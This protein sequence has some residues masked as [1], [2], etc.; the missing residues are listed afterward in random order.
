M[1]MAKTIAE[2]LMSLLRAAAFGLR[3]LV[4]GPQPRARKVL[5]LP[6]RVVVKAAKHPAVHGRRAVAVPARSTRR[7]RAV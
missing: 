3:D 7:R 6:R 1:K 5:P 2:R 4:F